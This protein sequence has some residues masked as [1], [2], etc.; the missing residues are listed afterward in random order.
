M[1]K[2][3]FGRFG[4]GAKYLILSLRASV[5]RLFS[6]FPNG[7]P[8]RGLLLLRLVAGALLVNDGI[9]E[10][11]GVVQWPGVARALLEIAAGL[12]LATGL[13]TP[14]TGVLIVMIE[15]WCIAS[16]AGEVRNA[17]VLATCGAALA[18]LG[19][20]AQSIDARLFGRRRIDLRER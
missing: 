12:L 20:G 14:I 5:Q 2:P 6:I 1:A 9:A 15:L 10:L 8:G 17:V 16:K 7:W 4:G 11:L 18:M 13:W 19:P 3:A